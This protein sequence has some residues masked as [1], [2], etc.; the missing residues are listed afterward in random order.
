MP[1]EGFLLVPPGRIRLDFALGEVGQRFADAP[2]LFGKIEVHVNLSA[3][4]DILAHPLDDV[5]S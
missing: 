4:R 5:F 1:R 3:G 2:L